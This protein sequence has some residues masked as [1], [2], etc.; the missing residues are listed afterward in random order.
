MYKV[1]NHIRYFKR[2]L[3]KLG[4]T[5]EKPKYMMFNGVPLCEPG[6]YGMTMYQEVD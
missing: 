5:D 6:A 2:A 4:L 1:N 3:W